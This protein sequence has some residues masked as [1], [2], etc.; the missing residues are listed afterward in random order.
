MVVSANPQSL[1]L[2]DLLLLGLSQTNCKLLTL[3]FHLRVSTIAVLFA[4]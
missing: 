1:H 4:L 3:H 2:Q